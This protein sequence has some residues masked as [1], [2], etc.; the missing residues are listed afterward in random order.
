VVFLQDF[1]LSFAQQRVVVTSLNSKIQI[2]MFKISFF[3]TMNMYFKILDLLMSLLDFHSYLFEK[4][5][6]KLTQ[7]KMVNFYITKT[8]YIDVQKKM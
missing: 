7:I 6:F 5:Y 2:D 4:L 1:V 8:R 3:N